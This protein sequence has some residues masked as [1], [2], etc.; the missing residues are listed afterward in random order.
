MSEAESPSNP[1]RLPYRPCVGIMLLN[2]QGLVWA[3]RRLRQSGQ[4]QENWQMPQGGI[5]P[6]EGPETAAFRELSEETG[7][8]HAQILAETQ[9]WHHYDLPPEMVGI[10]LKGKYCGQKQKWFAMRF[11]GSDDDFN[12]HAPPGGHHPEFDAWRWIHANDL[13]DIIIPFKRD[14][15]KAIIDEF[16]PFLKRNTE[17]PVA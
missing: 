10:A 4:T 1:S 17:N 9:I 2:A 15:Y 11:L 5:D 7:T 6:Q 8:G 3:G 14:V 12:I 16:Q 13:L